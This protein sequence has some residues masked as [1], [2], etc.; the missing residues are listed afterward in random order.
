MWVPGCATGE[1]AYTIAMLL[2]E[3]AAT[4]PEPPRVQVFAT[5]L[6]AAA[7]QHRPAAGPTPSP[8][9]PT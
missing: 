8:S 1:E 7:I 3:H 6:S 5:D 4:L 9:R 2:L